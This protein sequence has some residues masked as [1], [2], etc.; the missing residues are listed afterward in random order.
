MFIFAFILF[1]VLI[2]YGRE[3]LRLKGI[4]ISVAIWAALLLGTIYLQDFQYYFYAGHAVLDIV[5]VLIIFRGNIE[6]YR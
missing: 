3:E 2:Y 4:I 5:L 1:W 6:I